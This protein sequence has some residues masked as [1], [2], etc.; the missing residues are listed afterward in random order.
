MRVQI[1]DFT[2]QVLAAKRQR[3]SIFLREVADEMISISTPKTPKSSK[4][5][6]LRRS[7]LKVVQGLRGEV[8]WKRVYAAPQESG[9]IRRN[10]KIIRFRKYTTPGTGPGFAMYAADKVASESVTNRIGRR[11]GLIK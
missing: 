2:D 11:T 9:K 4:G 3:A 1:N 6:T 10:G 8:I 5:G 7:V